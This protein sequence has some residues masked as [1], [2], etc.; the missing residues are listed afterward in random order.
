[1][2]VTAAAAHD[3]LGLRISAER[4]E[5]RALLMHAIPEMQAALASQGIST[6]TIAV[7]SA[8]DPPGERRAPMRRDADRPSSR[9]AR[10][11]VA[12]RPRTSRSSAVGALDLTV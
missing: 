8:F 6:S 1:V 3:G 4:P 12:E 10:G 9:P 2:R 11:V 7:A 5:T